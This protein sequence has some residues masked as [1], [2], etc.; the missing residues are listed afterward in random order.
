M[1]NILDYKLFYSKLKV[2]KKYAIKNFTFL[3]QLK[4]SIQKILGL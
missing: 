3:T 1:N 4:F 2:V